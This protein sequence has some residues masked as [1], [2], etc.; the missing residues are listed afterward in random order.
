MDAPTRPPENTDFKTLTDQVYGARSV[1]VESGF[2][3]KN[4]REFAS[5]RDLPVNVK[6]SGAD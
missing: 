5:R 6:G 4:L 1:D 2:I 3:R